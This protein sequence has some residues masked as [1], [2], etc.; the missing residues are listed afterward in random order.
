MAL[1]ALGPLTLLS[2]PIM[3]C[4]PLNSPLLPL[5]SLTLPLHVLPSFVSGGTSLN[6]HF[7]AI[8]RQILPGLDKL[9][10][11]HKV[12]YFAPSCIPFTALH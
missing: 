4:Q 3:L 5:D 10:E 6:E 1:Y 8:Q 2:L 9:V 7:V 11:S 12:G